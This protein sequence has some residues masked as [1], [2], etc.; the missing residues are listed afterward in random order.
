M[1][2]CIC[3]GDSD[4]ELICSHCAGCGCYED[5]AACGASLTCDHDGGEHTFGE[6]DEDGGSRCTKCHQHDDRETARDEHEFAQLLA[7]EEAA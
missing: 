3:C 2:D 6:P 5:E 4:D 1:F 7:T